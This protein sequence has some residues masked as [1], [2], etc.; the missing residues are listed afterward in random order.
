MKK[1]LI[2]SSVM[3]VCLFVAGILSPGECRADPFFD[4]EYLLSENN[5]KGIESFIAKKANV[6]ARSGQGVTVLMAAILKDNLHVAEML[7][8]AGANTNA[9]TEAGL[10]PL[11]FAAT[12]GNADIVKLLLGKGADAS[13][14]DE[15]GK[16]AADYARDRHFNE[17]ADLLEKK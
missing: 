4:F 1:R 6:N 14:K 5:M 11:M 17:V 13:A 3:I 9:K 7:V 8:N 15:S 10:T 16:T 2:L 12:V